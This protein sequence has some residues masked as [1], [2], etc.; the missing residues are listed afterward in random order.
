VV[1]YFHGGAFALLS[2]ASA[3]YD[4]MCSRLYR[5]LHAPEHRCPA[6]FDD[7]GGWP[8]TEMGGRG[9][10]TRAGAPR[11]SPSGGSSSSAPSPPISSSIR[12]LVP[13]PAMAMSASPAPTF[14]SSP[15]STPRRQTP[16]FMAYPVD[17]QRRP[18]VHHPQH[19]AS[20]ARVRPLCWRGPRLPLTSSTR[21][22]LR[23]AQKSRK[24]GPSRHG[25]PAVV[26]G[27]PVRAA[28]G[29]RRGR[30][31]RHAQRLAVTCSAYFCRCL[32]RRVKGSAPSPPRDRTGPTP[33]W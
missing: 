29:P 11:G 16:T 31:V 15:T 18:R 25:R 22:I 13:N 27:A 23:T 17:A 33:A 4:A 5:D 24:T 9:G 32:P 2:A 12:E 8:S 28:T 20:P 14:I 30:F 7:G 19:R 26:V 3:T 21:S 10:R 6:T 1:V